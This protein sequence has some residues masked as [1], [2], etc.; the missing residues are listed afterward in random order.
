MK[1]DNYNKATTEDKIAFIKMLYST[2]LKK[3][4]LI[5][6]ICVAASSKAVVKIY[7]D[8]EVIG[9]HYDKPSDVIPLGSCET[10][11][12]RRINNIDLF[13]LNLIFQKFC[14]NSKGEILEEFKDLKPDKSYTNQ[15]RQQYLEN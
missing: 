10:W 14:T 6:D 2:I 5:Q 12:E 3:K 4:Y 11:T 13:I 8:G 9:I 15:N 7:T 1:I